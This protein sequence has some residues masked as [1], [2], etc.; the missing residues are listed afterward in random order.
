MVKITGHGRVKW[1]ENRGT[2]IASVPNKQR[3]RESLTVWQ[4]G[5]LVWGQV[6]TSTTPT[7][8]KAMP[9]Q[10][11]IDL[12]N[13]K[14]L[15]FLTPSFPL[16]CVYGASPDRKGPRDWTGDGAQKGGLGEA[17]KHSVIYIPFLWEKQWLKAKDGNPPP[18][19]KK[20]NH[21]KAE[22]TKGRK[23]REEE[24]DKVEGC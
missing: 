3:L 7:P 16:R 9:H 4:S 20:N 19:R 24:G 10:H 5:W 2:T 23:L 13:N 8:L 21:Q 15:C 12:R 18:I 17:P 11:S 22:G 1:C 6:S 14:F